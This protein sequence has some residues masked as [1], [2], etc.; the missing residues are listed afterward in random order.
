MHYLYLY[1]TTTYYTELF[2]INFINYVDKHI[3]HDYVVIHLGNSI[4]STPLARKR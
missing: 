3:K 4:L 1:I 2:A